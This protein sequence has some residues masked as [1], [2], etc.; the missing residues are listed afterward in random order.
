[1]QKYKFRA[2]KTNIAKNLFS[3]PLK[4]CSFS[5]TIALC[6]FSILP[7]ILPEFSTANLQKYS[8]V[9]GIPQ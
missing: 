9:N 2:I 3:N 4:N 7:I 5:H 8:H 6:S 1:L